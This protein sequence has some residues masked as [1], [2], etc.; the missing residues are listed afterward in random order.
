MAGFGWIRAKA[1]NQYKLAAARGQIHLS[2][3]GDITV[4]GT[5]IRFRQLFVA[6]QLL[7]A[8]GDAHESR[9]HV[10]PL[11]RARQ[12][13]A[14]PAAGRKASIPLSKAPFQALLCPLVRPGGAPKR[15]QA[16]IREIALKRN[17]ARVLND[18]V[19]ARMGVNNLFNAVASIFAGVRQPISRHAVRQIGGFVTS[20]K[21]LLGKKIL[22]IGNNQAE[23]ARARQ[24]GRG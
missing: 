3:E 1:Q 20:M 17:E 2:C 11:C 6:V 24:I 19:M 12:A 15:I 10:E 18:D 23:I 5:L 14:D 4:L 8:I 22:A 16:I 13:R 7:P 9:R 21:L